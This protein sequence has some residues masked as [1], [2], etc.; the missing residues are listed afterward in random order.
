MT[1]FASYSQLQSTISWYANRDDLFAA[2]TNFSPASI[3]SGIQIAITLAEAMVDR[4][5]N[6]RGGIKYSDTVINSLVLTAATETVTLPT[7]FRSVTSFMLTT[8]P[9]RVLIPMSPNQ[10][11]STYTSATVTGF[12]VAYSVIGTN[13][14]YLRPLP[15][16]S[17]Q[18]RLIYKAALAALSAANTSNWLLVNAPQVYLSASMMQLAMMLENDTA[19]VKWKGYYDQALDDLMGDDRQTR[20]TGVN[21]TPQPYGY[22][23]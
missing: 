4:D 6:S 17:Y 15:D 22:I 14:A 2:I 23:A 5:I 7:D 12:P 20:W 9:F 16:S 19:L 13:T 18:V 1:S 21:P 11:F 8:D 3:D 10:L